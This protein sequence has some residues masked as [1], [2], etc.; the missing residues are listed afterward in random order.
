M[1]VGFEINRLSAA[2]GVPPAQPCQIIGNSVSEAPLP[3]APIADFS[4]TRFVALT[5]DETANGQGR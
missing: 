4:K 5:W 3:A 2:L 1:T